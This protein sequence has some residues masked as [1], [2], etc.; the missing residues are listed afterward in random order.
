MQTRMWKN[1]A[2]RVITPRPRNEEQQELLL[3]SVD[4][5]DSRQETADF[6]I[7]QPRFESLGTV[8]SEENPDK[9]AH[10]QKVYDIVSLPNKGLFFFF[11]VSVSIMLEM[12]EE[13]KPT[14]HVSWS[15]LINL[16]RSS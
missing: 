11:A 15:T 1:I 4:G 3:G 13:C 9:P 12:H 14:P 10:H 8:L 16:P 7:E 2:N 5:V 6:Q